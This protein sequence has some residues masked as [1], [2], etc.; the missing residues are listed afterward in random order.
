LIRPERV[1]A[2]VD[3]LV[4]H[5]VRAYHVVELLE[6]EREIEDVFLLTK[7]LGL[8]EALGFF[9]QGL[10]VYEVAADDDVWVP[11]LVTNA[12]SSARAR[13]IRYGSPAQHRPVRCGVRSTEPPVFAP[14]LPARD[15]AVRDEGF[16]V[17]PVRYQYRG[18]GGGRTPRERPS[19]R[20]PW[21]ADLHP[22]FGN[23]DR[24]MS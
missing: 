18:D 23:S 16:R 3:E 4:I 2:L 19:A 14:A 9:Q 20:F 5:S 6:R 1:L 21:N 8:R 11:P 12:P 17:R 10:P 22:I 13:A 24:R 7:H 15:A